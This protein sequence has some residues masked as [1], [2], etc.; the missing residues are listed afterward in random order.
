MSEFI[1]LPSS[2]LKSAFAKVRLVPLRL[3]P[4]RKY[5]YI[6]KSDRP[7]FQYFEDLVCGISHTA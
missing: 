1:T 6:D 5:L 4:L 3:V 2:Y 7:Y